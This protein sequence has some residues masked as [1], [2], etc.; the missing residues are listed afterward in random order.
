[1]FK[2]ITLMCSIWF[3]NGEPK[4]SCFTHIFSWEFQTKEE[5]QFKI[6]NYSRF[7][8]PKNHKIILSE[9]VLAKKS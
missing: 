7:E 5:C 6:L 8:I 1:M 2:A 4:Q 3:I 9:C